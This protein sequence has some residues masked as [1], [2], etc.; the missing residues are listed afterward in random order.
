MNQLFL[1]FFIL[2][3]FVNSS[4]AQF[5]ELEKAYIPFN[6][7][8]FNGG[9][10]QGKS[11]WTSSAGTFAIETSTP[12]RGLAS[13]SWDASA[14]GQ[15]LTSGQFTVPEGLKG[16]ACSA[17]IVYK[18]GD[19]NLT[20]KVI[21]GSLADLG[22][23]AVATSTNATLLPIHFTCPTSGTFALRLIASNDAA[24]IYFDE[25]YL[26][27][28]GFAP[29]V[30]ALVSSSAAIT[31]S[32]LAS[33]SNDHVLINSGAGVM[34]SEATLSPVRGGTGV[35][36][37][38]AAT[39]TRSG[40][41][42]LTLTTTNT[43]GVTLPTTG[44]LYGTATGSIT[45]AE[46]LASLTNESGTG[47]SL[48]G[49]S[50]TIATPAINGANLNFGTAT[51]TNRLLLPTETT[52]NLDA[53][54]DTAGLIAYD[55]TQAKPVYNN[56]AAW[57]AVGTGSGSGS[58]GINYFSANPDAEVDV[59]SWTGGT[60]AAAST[61]ADLTGGADGGRWTRSTSSPL[62]GTGSFLFSHPA[63]N[64][65]GEFVSFP[66]TIDAADKGKIVQVSFD[67][68]VVSGTF[69]ST[70]SSSDLI[71]YAYDVTNSRLIEPANIYIQN[72]VAGTNNTHIATFQTPIDSTSLRFGIY[73]ASSN[74]AAFVMKFD[75]FSASQPTRSYGPSMLDFKNN[76]TFTPAPGFGTTTLDSFWYKRIGDIAHVRG[77]FRAGTTG[78][79]AAYITL[80]FTID[81]AKIS[82][83]NKAVR[84]GTWT[85]IVTGGAANVSSADGEGPIHID[86]A[87][88]SRVYIGVQTLSNIFSQPATS[89]IF[90]STDSVFVDF[91]VPVAGWSS[92]QEQ[93][94]STDTRVVAA[95]YSTAAGASMATGTNIIDYGTKDLDTHNAVTTGASWKFTAPVPGVYE[96]TGM[97]RLGAATF[98]N[99]AEQELTMFKNGSEYSSLGITRIEVTQT[100]AFA[101]AGSTIVSLNAGD[102][103]DLRFRNGE[104]GARS[105]SGDAK[106]NHVSIRRL[107]GPATISASETIYARYMTNSGQS[108]SNT[109][110][111]IIDIGTKVS[112]SHG[113]VT[114]GASWKA[115]APV[116]GF[117]SFQGRIQLTNDSDWTTGE[118]ATLYYY[119]N[120]SV[121]QQSE[122]KMYAAAATNFNPI[123][124]IN[125]GIY[126][127]A[128]EYIDFRINQSSGGAVAI[129]SGTPSVNDISIFRIG[130]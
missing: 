44:T 1:L 112:D 72:V 43:T 23:V 111:T 54:T 15:T 25:A 88:L 65:Q 17:V 107:S 120:G 38:A 28:S 57:V 45:S 37:N 79:T 70:A 104:A 16:L 7:I 50:P 114:T 59:A 47:V 76:L 31:R 6:S 62:R 46:L 122:M 77:S 14:N 118:N 105:L 121:I 51:N 100:N 101:V 103:I 106:L 94:S 108:I 91:M 53:L 81:T 39:L 96:V 78:A 99:T 95:R 24:I 123:F 82:S 67:Y 109:T 63:S 98:T 71:I 55:S 75:N 115:T 86:T 97:I 22:T 42:A 49:T 116:S 56:G 26:G 90:A 61:P 58:S 19:S 87:E 85:K 3:S 113:I 68:T 89:G 10:E 93:S 34:S 13:F 84:A 29:V 36:N 129:E 52:T 117:Y 8:V 64:I 83:T 48:F 69:V 41:H 4:H 11:G 20:F 92:S 127:N 119:K 130:G 66:L 128:G 40:N 5:R 9:A 18:G 2:F 110:T 126:L 124:I 102:Y 12:L 27:R 125:L 60:D 21:D 30:D 80:P 32:K 35:A 74:S 73:A 33:G